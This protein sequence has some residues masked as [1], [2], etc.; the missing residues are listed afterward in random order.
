MRAT[1]VPEAKVYPDRHNHK[2]AQCQLECLFSR[3]LSAEVRHSPKIQSNIKNQKLK[4]ESFIFK[5][6]CTSRIFVAQLGVTR[7]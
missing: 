4:K 7:L 2:V 3:R 5:F 1:D 6:Y